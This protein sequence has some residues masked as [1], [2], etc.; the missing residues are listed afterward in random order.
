ML[1]SIAFVA[2]ALLLRD[3]SESAASEA[4]AGA[5]F[6][7]LAVYLYSVAAVTLFIAPAYA[8]VEAMGRANPLTAALVGLLPGLAFLLYRVTPFAFID[9]SG[10]FLELACMATGASVAAATHLVLTWNG[11]VPPNNS[12]ERSRE[13]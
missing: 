9:G 5:A 13:R 7:A 8:L 3:P 6:I 2:A 10:P 12:L 4:L 11:T 1:L